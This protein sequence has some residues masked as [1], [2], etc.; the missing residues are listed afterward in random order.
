MAKKQGINKVAK[1]GEAKGF[2]LLSTTYVGKYEPLEWVCTLTGAIKGMSLFAM[3]RFLPVTEVE[4]R[5]REGWGGVP[6]R[7]YITIDR[8]TYTDCSTKA[9]FIDEV[10]GEVW[11]TPS[12]IMRGKGHKKRFTEGNK[13]PLGTFKRLLAE[14]RPGITL[15]D[16]TYDGMKKTATFV[17]PDHGPWSTSLPGDVLKGVTHPEAAKHNKLTAD[18]VLERVLANDPYIIGMKKDTYKGTKVKAI[19]IDCDYGEFPASPGHAMRGDARHPKRN[20]SR[21]LT[22]DEVEGRVQKICPGA[23]LDKSTYK[24]VVTKCRFTFLDGSEWIVR[25]SDV[26]TSYC[27]PP[28]RS[29][30]NLEAFA[31]NNFGLLFFNKQVPHIPTTKQCRPDFQLTETVFLNVHGLY[32]HSEK[33]KRSPQHHAKM[34]ERFAAYGCRVIQLYEDE[35]FYKTNVVQSLIDGISGKHR[36][37]ESK[38]CQISSVDSD[39]F[40]A[41]HIAGPMISHHTV[42]V[43]LTFKNVVVCAMSYYVIGGDLHIKFCDAIGTEVVGGFQ[44]LL[45][46][47]VSVCSPNR[48]VCMVDLRYDVETTYWDLGFTTDSIVVDWKWTDGRRTYGRECTNKSNWYKIHD[49]GQVKLVRWYKN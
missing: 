33:R 3:K 5:I 23:M 19:F 6:P 42:A 4:R 45:T 37:I 21:K 15:V 44:T 8:S 39:F 36:S 13:V 41:N 10:Y 11:N 26:F 9:R 49:A 12:L 28:S 46:H 14:A 1:V 20:P 25:P 22:P 34:R 43:G 47:I 2:R 38:R 18:E 48:V 35:V 17:H 30:T 24:N 31:S 7:S 27:Q 32:N 29:A 40:A 16:S